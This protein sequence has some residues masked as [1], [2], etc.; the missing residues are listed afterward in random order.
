MWKL[1]KLYTLKRCFC[2]CFH[3]NHTLIPVLITKTERFLIIPSPCKGHG[4]PLCSRS[5]E[6]PPALIFLGTPVLGGFQDEPSC[7]DHLLTIDGHS[8]VPSGPLDMV[9]HVARQRQGGTY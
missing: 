1:I 3:V 9:V 2:F 8:S 7:L 6:Q 5:Q 4:V